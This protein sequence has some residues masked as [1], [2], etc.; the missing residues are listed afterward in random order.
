MKHIFCIFCIFLYG[1]TLTPGSHIDISGND[2]QFT[3]NGQSVNIHKIT[4]SIIANL[5]GAQ[6]NNT[7][8]QLEDI[9]NKNPSPYKIGV[10]DVITIVVWDHPELTSPLGQFRSSDE[11][12]N[13]VYEDGTIY[14]PYAGKVKVLGK[15]VVEIR[16]LVTQQLTSFI[17]KPQVDVRVAAYKSQRYVISGNVTQ[18]GVYPINNIPTRI[19]DALSVSGGID[20]NGNIFGAT[21]TRDGQKYT[22][23]IYEMLYNGKLQYNV[24][25]QE[26]D[27]I[28]IQENTRRQVF[29]MG[30]VNRPVSVPLT[31][32]PLSLTEAISQAGGINELRADANGI[33]VVRQ[34]DEYDSI[35]IYQLDVSQA[36][37]LAL[38]DQ[39]VLQSRDVVYV[40]AAPIT[41]WNR[42][43][44]NILPSI[45]SIR[46]LDDIGQ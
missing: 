11:Q 33:Y 21:L 6:T 5:A 15:T 1:C 39:F 26:N 20:A 25:L 17:E 19:L 34:T 28:H 8:T 41:R 22:L 2:P 43:I 10:G 46:T 44:S 24:L 38:A 32:L 18:P 27:L 40:S 31:T 13:V 30:E 4:P 3:D 16:E 7:N 14:Y 45:T 35:D 36:Y 29:V 12:G 23:P 42:F 9:I 37:N